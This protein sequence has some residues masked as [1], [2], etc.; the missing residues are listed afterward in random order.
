[1]HA[2]RWQRHVKKDAKC[3]IISLLKLFHN[4]NFLPVFILYFDYYYITL[5]VI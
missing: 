4:P 2:V 1:M 3:I 5:A